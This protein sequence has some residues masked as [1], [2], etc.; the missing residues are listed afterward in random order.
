[1]LKQHPKFALT[2]MLLPLLALLF[3]ANVQAQNLT[4]ENQKLLDF[5]LN[6]LSLEKEEKSIAKA[7]TQTQEN[8]RQLQIALAPNRDAL[9]KAERTLI[10]VQAENAETPTDANTA[11]VENAKFKVFLASRKYEKTNSKLAGAEEK[12]A[13]LRAEQQTKQEAIAQSKRNI[14]KQIARIKWFKTKK[15]DKS[16]VKTNTAESS[17]NKKTATNNNK[18]V[19][20]KKKQRELEASQAEIARLKA[21]LK[22]QSSASTLANNT[23][24]TN[25]AKNAN[26]NNNNNN[27][28]NAAQTSSST[29]QNTTLAN[30]VA[31]EKE[32]TKT[33]AP[34]DARNENEA[35]TGGTTSSTAAKTSKENPETKARATQLVLKD[36]KESIEQLMN[37]ADVK[38]EKRR[39]K[40]E[41]YAEKLADLLAE[42]SPATRSA[43]ADENMHINALT[44]TVSSEKTQTLRHLI[45]RQYSATLEVN[46]GTLAI[47]AAD[48]NWK[49]IVP[50]EDDGK[51][52][53]FLFD[54]RPGIGP[55]LIWYRQ[56]LAQ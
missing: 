3:G 12:L 52:Y 13:Q 18:D 51:R 41:Y 26:N 15:D 47:S 16:P 9:D 32:S 7:I 54:N 17:V 49:V 50:A 1:M 5:Q 25:Q 53:Q 56:D 38:L 55:L 22:Q 27:N 21:L 30:N 23:P 40:A 8:I 35:V 42:A 31:S 10:H 43:H 45:D 20:L 24:D 14:E 36:S 28:N 19:A 34:A 6:Q 11:K 37:D 29:G 4:R 39:L 48:M 46:T 44:Q 33:G 2:L